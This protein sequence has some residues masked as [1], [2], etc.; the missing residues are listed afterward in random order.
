MKIESGY[1]TTTVAVLRWVFFIPLAVGGALL[2]SFLVML[3][4]RLTIE[5]M[6]IHLD[7]LPVRTA[8]ETMSNGAMGAAFVYIG[9]VIVPD[10]R[11]IVAYVMA[12]V[13]LVGGGFALFAAVLFRNLW[14]VW[15]VVC[16]VAGAGM[17]AYEILANGI[18]GRT[19]I[20]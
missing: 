20:R 14:M 8:I 5:S 7:S 4:N 1:K 17:M 15:N 13:S 2:A 18:R 11:R 9:A 12:I 10:H 19:Q 3:G 16:L 6:G